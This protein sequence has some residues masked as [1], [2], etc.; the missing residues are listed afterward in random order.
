[1]ATKQ[2]KPRN[3]F[4]DEVEVKNKTNLKDSFV[5]FIFI[6]EMLFA[7]NSSKKKSQSKEPN[8]IQDI[9]I[10]VAVILAIIIFS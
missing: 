10:M 3:V 9:V 8:G 6:W 1:M 4:G 7:N 5:W 2:Y